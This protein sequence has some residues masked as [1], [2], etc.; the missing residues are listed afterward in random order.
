MSVPVPMLK[1]EEGRETEGTLPMDIVLKF[2]VAVAETEMRWN[3]EVRGEVMLMMNESKVSEDEAAVKT[4]LDCWNDDVM[5]RAERE[6]EEVS[7][8]VRVNE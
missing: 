8:D 2:T 3:P 5:L 1:R 4:C 6:P 7:P